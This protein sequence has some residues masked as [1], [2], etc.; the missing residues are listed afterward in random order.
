[1]NDHAIY[2]WLLVCDLQSLLKLEIWGLS[3]AL[4]RHCT[5]CPCR[6]TG[7]RFAGETSNPG[8]AWRFHHLFFWDAYM[9]YWM[10][11]G[12]SCTANVTVTMTATPIRGG[13]AKSWTTRANHWV[14]K[15]H[16]QM[17]W[18]CTVR[19]I[20]WVV[21][22]NMFYFHPENGGRWTHF[23][24]HIFQ[25]GWFNHQLDPSIPRHPE[26]SCHTWWV[27]GCCKPP[28]KPSRR[29]RR[30]LKNVDVCS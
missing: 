4:T 22:P 9:L 27:G 24:E 28:K 13:Y 23:D 18:A 12:F 2:H 29:I 6:V 17:M 10:I 26:S 25:R 30:C 8:N 21:V 11:H 16:S 1:M 3:E 15:T 19:I 7:R 5:L 14:S 20:N